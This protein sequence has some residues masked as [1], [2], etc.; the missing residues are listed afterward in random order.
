MSLPSTGNPQESPLPFP[1]PQQ[2]EPRGD[3]ERTFRRS[4]RQLAIPVLLFFLTLISTTLAGADMMYLFNRDLAFTLDTDRYSML[5]ASPKLLAGGLIFS[6]PLLLILFAHEMGHF[7][8]CEYYQVDATY[9]YF[10]PFPTPIG[11]MGAFI[12]IRAP[13][14]SRRALFD[15]A[16]AGP[17][18]GFLVLLPVLLVGISMSKV[19]NNLANESDLIFGSPELVRVL[20]SYL[21]PGVPQDDIYLH[22]AARAA[23]VGLLATA[24]NLIPIGQ[25][26]GGHIIYA[27]TGE[28]S[29]L[30]YRVGWLGVLYLAAFYSWGTWLVW[31]V[32]LLFL[33]MWHP[34]IYDSNPL[35]MKRVLLGVF[36]LVMFLL[37]FSA[38]PIRFH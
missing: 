21:F 8:A 9:P 1:G 12:R 30:I 24:L 10:I 38:Q 16:I 22:P 37:S 36:A 6:L 17:I 32:L 2:S 14:F 4:K 20:C 19:H 5:L 11:T 13:I 34:V 23:W 35:G 31:A 3:D 28:F 7:L 15:I 27:F 25:L 18:A 33:G 29:K 26:D